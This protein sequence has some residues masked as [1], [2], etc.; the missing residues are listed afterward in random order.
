MAARPD[1]RANLHLHTTFSDGELTPAA[2]VEAPARAGFE[3]IALTDHDTLDGIDALGGLEGQGLRMIAGVELS[4]EDQ[5]E[6]GLVQAHLLGYG[7]DLRNRRLRQRLKEASEAREAQKKETVSRLAA[8]GYQ[9]DWDSVRARARGNV[10]KPHIVAAIEASNPGVE[11]KELYRQ[12][13][14]GG[15]ANVP[16]GRDLALED[17]VALIAG[18]GG[19][20]VLAHPGVYDHVP[21]LEMLFHS[22]ASAGVLG[23]EV[24]YPQVP[25]D[26]YG[27][28]SSALMERFQERATAYGWVA[29][30]GDDF[31]GPAVTPLIRLAEWKATPASCVE[32]LLARRP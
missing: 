22:C 19:V 6:R 5:P 10:G 1:G 25:L 11:R 31:H 14:P 30:G 24:T 7:F 16:R 3:V 2:V 9:V 26:P 28:R 23:L 32:E 15:R 18:A 20:T 21:D 4:I 29:T 17:A 8:L 27:P 12:M 13:G